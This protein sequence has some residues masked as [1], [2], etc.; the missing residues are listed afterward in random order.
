MSKERPTMAEMP[1]H[2]GIKMRCYP[3]TKQMQMIQKG[4]DASRFTYNEMVARNQ[5]AYDCVRLSEA[6]FRSMVLLQNE[7]AILGILETPRSIKRY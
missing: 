7:R 1:Y 4:I 3:S 6:S 2:F 5:D